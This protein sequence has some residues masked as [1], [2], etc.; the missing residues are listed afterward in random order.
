MKK[1]VIVAL[2]ISFIFGTINFILFSI[3]KNELYSN[4]IWLNAL[5]IT[6]FA[7][8]FS[9][10]YFIFRRNRKDVKEKREEN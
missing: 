6:E 8:V 7:I 10:S 2:I 4:K 3:F 9:V 1:L 5:Y